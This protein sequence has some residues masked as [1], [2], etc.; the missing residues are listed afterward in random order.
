MNRPAND[1]DL[2]AACESVHSVLAIVAAFGLFAAVG[3]SWWLL[4][5]LRA[6]GEL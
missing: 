6:G 1:N 5:A 3:V 4:V 2:L